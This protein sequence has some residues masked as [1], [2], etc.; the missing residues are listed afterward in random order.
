[1]SGVAV[2]IVEE[3]LL[4][5]FLYMQ[6]IFACSWKRSVFAHSINLRPVSLH[7]GGYIWIPSLV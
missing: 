7:V 6:T 3:K 5:E 1:M 2:S 4:A